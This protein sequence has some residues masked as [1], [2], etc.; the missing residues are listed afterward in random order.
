MHLHSGRYALVV[1]ILRVRRKIFI[2]L[3]SFPYGWE[4][5]KKDLKQKMFKAKKLIDFK[6]YRNPKY[7]IKEHHIL[8]IIPAGSNTLIEKVLTSVDEINKLNMEFKFDNVAVVTDND[9]ENSSNNFL[10]ELNRFFS[11][12]NYK[13]NSNI[14]NNE[15]VKGYYENSLKE[16]CEIELLPILIPF[17]ENGALET[18]LL[19]GIKEIDM[20]HSDLVK[21]SYS[22]IDTAYNKYKE[23]Y[24]RGR[25][26][27][28]KAKFDLVFVIMT[29]REEYVRRKEYLQDNIKWHRFDS[30][31]N[32]F[33]K[34]EYLSK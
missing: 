16:K 17:S 33:L 34:L 18:I 4:Y 2:C 29:T 3:S 14:N 24:L 26:D 27:C 15:W 12:N 19:E 5:I 7:L 20:L 30:V 31:N 11:T 22:T 25:S 23:K 32:A 1:Q 21:F 10:S 13:F 8:V 6:Q 28:L 9:D